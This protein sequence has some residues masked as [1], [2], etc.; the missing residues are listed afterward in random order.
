[1]GYNELV[2]FHKKTIFSSVQDILFKFKISNIWS[3]RVFDFNLLP[4]T[5]RSRIESEVNNYDYFIFSENDH[6]WKEFHVDN[7]IEYEKILPSN[8]ISGLIQFEENESGRYYP[9][10]HANYE[11]DYESVEFHSGKYFAHFSNLHQAS[12]LIS[13][14][15]LSGTL[16]AR[17]DFSKFMG[18][19]KYSLKC[20]A[21]TDIF[22]YCGF[23][24]VIC[25][26]DFDRNIIH[27]M[28]NLYI[29]GDL[30]RK[31]LRSDE[32]RMDNALSKLL[33]K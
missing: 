20:K 18:N 24:K 9:G 8:R 10:Y 1:M 23:K 25:I 14:K 3:G 15:Q 13:N 21:N 6:L 7:F 30:G 19:D 31:K 12:F 17:R 5:C 4:M 27:H 29:K 32:D 28:P 33:K 26:S 2:L 11:W 22:Q 16:L